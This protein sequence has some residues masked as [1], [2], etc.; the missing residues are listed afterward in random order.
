MT[1]QNFHRLI[2]I[3]KKKVNRKVKST[4]EFCDSLRMGR[5]CPNTESEILVPAHCARNEPPQYLQI[6]LSFLGH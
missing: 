4:A 6:I 3:Y 5:T 2:Y 1:L